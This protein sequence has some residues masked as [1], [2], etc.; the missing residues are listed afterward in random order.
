MSETNQ[1]ETKPKQYLRNTAIS[2]GVITAVLIAG[3][4][5]YTRY[6]FGT[7]YS[8]LDIADASLV[9]A[10]LDRQEVRYRVGKDGSSI[11]VPEQDI[12]AVRLAVYSSNGPTQGLT[13]FELFNE[14]EM[15]LTDFA[16]K[17]KFQRAI[18]GELS[19]TIMMMEGV[20]KARVHVAIP[21]RSVFRSQ[22]TDATAAVT[23]IAK[24]GVNFGDDSI[25]GIQRL[26]ASSIPGLNLRQ[27]TVVD[28]AGRI[29]SKA[30]EIFEMVPDGT[31]ESEMLVSVTP[32]NNSNGMYQ[33]ASLNTSKPVKSPA[34]S[35][36]TVSKPKQDVVPIAVK[37]ETPS[38]DSEAVETVTESVEAS[39][40]SALE[41][42]ESLEVSA[43]GPIANAMQG[44]TG[45]SATLNRWLF[46]SLVGLTLIFL[47][48]L[49]LFRRSRP[50]RMSEDQRTTF[51]MELSEALRST[52]LEVANG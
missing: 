44:E 9:A 43:P 14:S 17:I 19:R 42:A 11:L 12:E 5:A 2:F 16:Q 48:G 32:K 29:I 41:F 23:L 52:E 45:M 31:Y 40:P 8:G 51:A 35:D 37:A 38:V 39:I 50:S 27:V 36:S 10:E 34:S 7:L 6:D 3:Y 4:L 21:E 18:Q 30:S 49:F 22:R 46:P 25:L 47:L 1:I 24:D 28:G 13:G 15:G 20:K 33:L 26:V